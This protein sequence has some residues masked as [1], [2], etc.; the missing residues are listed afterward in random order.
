MRYLIIII[1]LLFLLSACDEKQ[2]PNNN[3]T[4]AFDSLYTDISGEYN[5]A[6]A[7]TAVN[8]N[9]YPD[10]YGKTGYLISGTLPKGPF[11]LYTVYIYFEDD[12][13]GN[14]TFDLAGTEGMTRFSFNLGLAGEETLGSNISG[15]INITKLTNDELAG[16]FSYNA[17]NPDST[18][19]ITIN[20]G[21]FTYTINN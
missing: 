12:S 17:T 18:K 9:L 13:T 4:A 8:V 10:N 21:Y 1:S 7:T 16:N 20:N 5:L 6:L 11:E 14:R 2:L 3:T 15:E 19:F